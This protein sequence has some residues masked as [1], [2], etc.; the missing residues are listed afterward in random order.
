MERT[1]I[2]RTTAIVVFAGALS[3]AGAGVFAAMPLANH[4]WSRVGSK[5]PDSLFLTEPME[6]VPLPG[7]YC[8]SVSGARAGLAVKSASSS[9]SL[10]NTDVGVDL[11]VSGSTPVPKAPSAMCPVPPSGQLPLHPALPSKP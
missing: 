11:I 10:G 3:G 7:T 8:P 9:E 1:M 2:R 4:H 5:A 6:N